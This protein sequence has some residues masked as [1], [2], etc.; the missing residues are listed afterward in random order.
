MCW[1]VLNMYTIA[2]MKPRHLREPS[3][4]PEYF[5]HLLI[6]HLRPLAPHA[7]R[8]LSGHDNAGCI[9]RGSVGLFH[10]SNIV[11]RKWSR[12]VP[13]HWHRLIGGHRVASRESERP[14]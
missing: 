2:Y 1:A 8:S 3:L 10:W 6:N 7:L 11:Y 13:P 4:I 5:L 14:L 12:A 9:R